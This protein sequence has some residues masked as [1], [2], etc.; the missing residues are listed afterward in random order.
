MEE[1]SNQNQIEEEITELLIDSLD[2]MDE[3]EL[4]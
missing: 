2:Q 1:N 4:S 3:E